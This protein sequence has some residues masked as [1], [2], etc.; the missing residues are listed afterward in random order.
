MVAQIYGINQ[1]VPPVSYTKALDVWTGGCLSFIVLAI[2]EVSIVGYNIQLYKY[3]Q[4]M[5][6]PMMHNVPTSSRP[7][8]G[9]GLLKRSQ[10]VDV[11]S[12]I[13]FPLSFL[14]FNIA[15]WHAYM[16]AEREEGRY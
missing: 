16:F 11:V 2:I 4:S 10:K 9:A 1:G 13:L 3:R 8:L 15:Y 6:L 7:T 14:L 12:R 5:P